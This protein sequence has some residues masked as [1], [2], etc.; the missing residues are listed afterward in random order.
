M[1]VAYPSAAEITEIIAPEVAARQ[2]AGRLGFELMP[3][4]PKRTIDVRWNIRDNFTGLISLRGVGGE[5]ESLARPGS[6]EYS[7]KAGV[8]G[9]HIPIG[10]DELLRR[11]G[12][13]TS[14]EPINVDD[15]VVEAIDTLT[16]ARL[17]MQEYLIWELLQKGEFK[18]AN[19]ANSIEFVGRFEVQKLKVSIPWSNTSSATPLAN[20]RAARSLMRGRGSTFRGAQMI[21]NDKT[22]S[23]LMLNRNAAD[24]YGVRRGG[25][26]TPSAGVA[27]A[28]EYLNAEGLPT[29]REYDA[30]YF[31]AGS[32]EATPYVSDKYAIIIGARLDG[33]PIGNSIICRNMLTPNQEPA[34]YSFVR[35]TTGRADEND[36]EV[37]PKIE[38][39]HGYNGGP[40]IYYPGSIVILEIE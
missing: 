16:E 14:N 5:P 37:P 31:L 8:F 38:V 7:Y 30:T 13:N 15:L 29:I 36:R 33:S 9:S 26:D 3:E 22:M 4:I 10:E 28:N 17:N 35:D 40:V 1:N 20:I 11:R 12:D 34:P 24:F 27:M 18:I 6:K 25:G 21:V 2:M 39:H 19:G 32:T 23:N